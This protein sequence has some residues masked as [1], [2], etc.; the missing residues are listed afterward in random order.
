MPYFDK[1]CINMPPSFPTATFAQLLDKAREALHDARG[2]EP[3]WKEFALASNIIGWRYRTAFDELEFLRGR[4]STTRGPIDHED[5]YQREHALFVLFT[6]GVSC[7]EAC[8]YATAAYCSHVVG[9]DF[10]IKEQHVCGPSKLQDW[11][12]S[13]DR[14]AALIAV[15]KDIEDSQ[16]WQFWRRVRNRLSHRGNLPAII[17]ASV[18]CPTPEVN[19][20]IFDATTST[21]A[22][23]MSVEELNT[24]FSWLTDTINRLMHATVAL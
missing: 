19:P 22:I 7:V 20:I 12:K 14:A 5:I 24:H 2:A 4:Y 16:E 9:F 1:L 8:I 17:Y 15:L 21:G 11:L 10:G 6:A 18:G 23:D 3:K 13:L